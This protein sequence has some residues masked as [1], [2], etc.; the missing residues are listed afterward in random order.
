[1]KPAIDSTRLKYIAKCLTTVNKNAGAQL[2]TDMIYTLDALHCTLITIENVNGGNVIATQPFTTTAECLGRGLNRFKGTI[3]FAED[4]RSHNIGSD[5]TV[6]HVPCTPERLSDSLKNVLAKTQPYRTSVG[7][8]TIEVLAAQ[9]LKD[10]PPIYIKTDSDGHYMGILDNIQVR[11]HGNFGPP[12]YTIFA[13]AY[14]RKLSRIA[15]GDVSVEWD[16]LSIIRFSWDAYGVKV[17][18]LV[19]PRI[20]NDEKIIKRLDRKV[21]L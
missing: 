5:V 9:D 19:A 8:K 7:A 12:A 1:M 15:K 21:I 4:G 2:G 11:M 14:L 16:N 10:D 6:C 18:Y 17:N 13:A 3:S 20:V